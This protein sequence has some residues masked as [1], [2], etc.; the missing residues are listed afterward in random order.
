M[1]TTTAAAHRI[2]ILGPRALYPVPWPSWRALFEPGESARSAAM[3]EL[4]GASAVHLWNELSAGRAAFAPQGS[5]LEQVA[6]D[7]CPTALALARREE[8]EEKEKKS[9]GNGN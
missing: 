1:A 3:A 2:H 8:E 9:D 5:A 6:R 4:R 7:N